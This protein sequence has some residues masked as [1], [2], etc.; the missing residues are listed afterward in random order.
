MRRL[1][2]AFLAPAASETQRQ[3]FGVGGHVRTFG[4]GD[5]SFSRQSGA[6]RVRPPSK[7]RLLKLGG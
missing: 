2:E 4:P 7:S 3:N 6:A 1:V 5:M